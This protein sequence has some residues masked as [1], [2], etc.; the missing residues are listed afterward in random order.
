M[1]ADS[2]PAIRTR[3]GALALILFAGSVG[4]AQL[5]KLPGALPEIRADLGIGLV[6]AGWIVSTIVLIGALASIA[7]GSVGDRIG[8]R[9]VAC[10]GAALL[11]IGCLAGAAAQSTGTL[12]ASRIVEGYGYIAVIPPAP[13][14]VARSASPADRPIAFGIWSFY[15]PFGM[16]AMVALSPLLMAATG[17]WRG[18]WLINAALALLAFAGLRAG[19]RGPRFAPL[20]TEATALGGRMVITGEAIAN[21]RVLA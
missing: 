10:T 11:G 4:A 19:V 12:S 1:P 8:H 18:L 16:A 9:R 3:W 5:G 17:G 21:H 13:V 14:L 15:M 7:A 20:A 2:P 6:T